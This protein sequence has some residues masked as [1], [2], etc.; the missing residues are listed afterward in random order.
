MGALGPTIL[1][2]LLLLGPLAGTP[3]DL[4][5][6]VDPADYFA[7]RRIE[8]GAGSLRELASGSPADAKGLFQQLL[9]IRWL[10]E[11]KDRLGE[12][13]EAVRRALD[14]L[15]QGPDG[16]ARDQARVA[17]A[18]L[19]GR[20]PPALHAA[21]KDS[22]REA[23]A[24]FPQ[25]VSLVGVLDTR[26]PAGQQPAGRPDPELDRLARRLPPRVMSTMPP[27]ARE[28]LYRMGE[29]VGNFRLDRFAI[30]FALDPEGSGHG[31][32]FLRGT[33]RMD[34]Q[35]LAAY[36]REKIGL[37]LVAEKKGLRGE[38]ITVLNQENSPPAVALI[39]DSDL[40]MAGYM[41]DAIDSAALMDKALAVRD[42]G[43]PG[44]LT[45]P[46]GKTLGD[47]PPGACGL[48]RG[49]LPREWVVSLVR[50]PIGA[51]PRQVAL[52]LVL[53]AAAD[54][55]L[56]LRARG[57]FDDEAGARKFADALR[58]EVKQVADILKEQP[59]P[60]Q[61]LG[62]ATIRKTVDGIAIKADGSTAT[63]QVGVSAATLRTLLTIV[64]RA[65]PP[66]PGRVPNG[67]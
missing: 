15:A 43:R 7:S 64:E 18:R 31:R 67:G 51:A 13:R 34:H 54:A 33:G 9:A 47:V 56:D 44:L 17:L 19:D 20:P 24:W 50:S 8:V 32:I 66:G 2:P 65:M 28:E 3:I 60:V 62:L 10:G 49:V 26:A 42:G 53:P 52:D 1:L 22:L 45:G 41:S 16:F 25:D 40:L 21:P 5:A 61:L 58:G 11:N 37:G 4:L 46:L 36:F 6:L 39:G 38:A 12:H 57:T 63:G 23:L 55:A 14:R 29:A 48:V 59:L 30:G 35:R 27:E